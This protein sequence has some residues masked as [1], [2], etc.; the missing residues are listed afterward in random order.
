VV[1]ISAAA[2][3]VGLWWPSPA[4]SAEA[5]AREIALNHVKALAPDL[6]LATFEE[7]RE[8]MTKLDFSVATPGAESLPTV[9][10][11]G[12]RYCSLGGEM[13]AQ[14]RLL[15]AANRPC[16]L[17]QVRDGEAFRHLQPTTV[18]VDGVRVRIWREAG[19]VMGLAEST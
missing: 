18:E 11:T 10:V 2:F 15:D 4:L 6:T 17:Y 19:L 7:A 14:F 9:R 8:A 13:A 1:A 16:T 5:V 3:A 12:A